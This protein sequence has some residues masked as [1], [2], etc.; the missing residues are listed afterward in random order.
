M[1][2]EFIDFD[3]Y[4][5][6]SDG[7]IY[8]KHFGRPLKGY[9][10]KDG[11][12]TVKLKTKDG[13]N[14]FLYHRVIWYFFNGEI[15]DGIQVNHKN[16]NKTNN[17]LSNLN[18]L[19]PEQNSNWGTRNERMASKLKGRRPSDATIK[20]SVEKCRREVSKY[21]LDGKLLKIYPSFAEAE[22]DNNCSH[23]NII[24]CCQGKIKTYK[25]FK[26]LYG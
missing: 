11:Y 7:I 26:W 14:N 9:I 8:S 2:E 17:A 10:N 1:K 22:R 4:N 25:G 12:V 15:P 13:F 18:L 3:S 23:A 19:T 5:I 6:S 21:S 20:A 16:E 24:K